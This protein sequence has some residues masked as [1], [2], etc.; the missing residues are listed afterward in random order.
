MI[1]FAVLF[2]VSLGLTASDLHRLR[3]V[4]EVAIRPDGGA[5]L[6]TELDSSGRGQPESKL[7]IYDRATGSVRPFRSSG[8]SGSSPRWSPNG[9]RVA[10][11]GTH[12]G[13]FGLV[14]T[15]AR[16]GGE[17]LVAK[18]E[19]TNHPLPSSGET[20]AWAPDSTSLA[21]ISATPGPEADEATGDPVVI[22]RY[23]YKPTAS[24]GETRFNDNRR[25]HVFLADATGAEPPRQLTDGS[26]YEHSV[27]FSPKGDEIL[28]VSNR[29]RDPDRF[30]NYDLFAL[31]VEDGSVRRLTRTE[32]AEYRPQWSPDGASIVY[33]GTARGLTSSETTM[34]D[35]HIWIM[36]SDGSG[37]REL[38][39]LDNRQSGPSWSRDG[40]WVYFTVQESGTQALYRI[41]A[42]GGEAEPVVRERGRVGA[43]SLSDSGAVAYAFHAPDDLAQLHLRDPSGGS[44]KLTDSNRE[45][46][47]AATLAGPFPSSS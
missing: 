40:E 45:L 43:F 35:T 39:S 6:F 11:L 32:N 8:L 16:G 37:R 28:F 29:D 31:A 36:K 5:I 13:A 19:G 25:T 38:S 24:E 41:R 4:R 3:S 27:S 15:D 47:G 9:E 18:V 14:V 46:L 17:R 1:H 10:L 2:A 42:S 7:M 23:L 21:F 30:F 12:D 26:T 34:E 44:K 22:R 20:V 33:E